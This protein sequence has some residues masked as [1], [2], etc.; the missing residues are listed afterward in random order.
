MA[1]KDQI[2]KLYNRDEGIGSVLEEQ[3]LEQVKNILKKP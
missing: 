3:K 1:S 2:M